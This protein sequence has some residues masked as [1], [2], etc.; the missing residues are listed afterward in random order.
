MDASATAASARYLVISPVRNE[1]AHIAGTIAS[2]AAQTLPPAA[3]IV[4]DDGSTDGTTDVLEK[5]AADCSWLHLHRRTDRGRRKSGAGVMEA[6]HDGL[7]THRGPDW[8]YI[9]K[10]DGDLS[11]DAEYFARCLKYF[12]DDPKLGIGGGTVC[13]ARDGELVEEAPGD[14]VFHVRG[15]TKIYRRAC[16]DAIGGLSRMTGWDTL[17]EV[18]ANMLGWSTRTFPDARLVHHRP[19][20]GADGSWGDAF[21]NGRGA[22]ICGYHP[23]FI[24]LKSMRRALRRPFVVVGCGLLAG[25]LSGYWGRHPRIEDRRLIRYL[26]DQQLRALMGRPTIWRY[27]RATL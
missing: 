16:W 13:V 8:D 2:M 12:E 21:K 6:F 19:T 15:A 25:Y 26:R 20:G 23:L 11:F 10:L 3:W 4:V 1:A 5:A 24:L 7:A 9:V 27:R 22:Y 18:K 17:D 14:P